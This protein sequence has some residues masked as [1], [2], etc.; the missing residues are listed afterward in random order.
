MSPK[1]GTGKILRWSLL[2]RALAAKLRS[3]YGSRCPENRQGASIANPCKE[4]FRRTGPYGVNVNGSRAKCL[5]AT[6][7]TA[8]LGKLV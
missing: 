6:S 5:G 1:R 7:G 3:A 4:A 8:R 2:E